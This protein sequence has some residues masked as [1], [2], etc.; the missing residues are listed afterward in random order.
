MEN[1][2]AITIQM[3]IS[4]RLLCDAMVRKLFVSGLSAF[5]SNQWVFTCPGLLSITPSPQPPSGVLSFGVR[6]DFCTHQR[7]ITLADR[8][9][10]W[11]HIIIWNFGVINCSLPTGGFL[12]YLLSS[13]A[14]RNFKINESASTNCCYWKDCLR[15]VG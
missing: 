5:L 11:K 14:Y 15:L 13:R 10:F 3:I 1:G 4:C 9:L 12:L 2:K 8:V 6:N 7:F